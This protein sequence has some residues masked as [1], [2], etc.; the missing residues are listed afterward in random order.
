MNDFLPPR[1]EGATGSCVFG[2]FRAAAAG[3]CVRDI[4]TAHGPLR[5]WVPEA[6]LAADH[7]TAFLADHLQVAPGARVA[8]PGCGSGFLGLL[9]ARAGAAA[10]TG[11][12]LDARLVAAARR[13]AQ[14]NRLGN[15]RFVTG[16]LLEPVSGP[17]DLVIAILPHKPGPRPFNRRYWGGADG[18]DLLRAVVEQASGRLAAAGRLLLYANSIANPPRLARA[19]GAHFSV[20][21]LAEKKRYFTAAEFDWLDPGLASYLRAQAARGEAELGE[22]AAGCYFIARIWEGTR[23]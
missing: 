14:L 21:L 10:V 20:R 15:A 11:T 22:D 17:L 19:L 3:G 18:T 8:E 23:R 7:A 16:D 9:A 2:P 13:N 5:E 1:A 6:A 12:D 4:A